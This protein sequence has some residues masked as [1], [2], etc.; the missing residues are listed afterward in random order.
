MFY[1]YAYPKPEGFEAGRVE[2]DAAY[3]HDALHEYVLP[4]EAVRTAADP[5]A[6]LL[7]FLQSTYRRGG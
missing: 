1:S 6:A 5:D 2:P 4:Y 3:F 7:A